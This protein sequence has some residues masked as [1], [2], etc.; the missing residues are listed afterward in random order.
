M[1]IYLQI[2]WQ[3]CLQ[4]II[5]RVIFPPSSKKKNTTNIGGP[6]T[7]NC[8]AFSYFN[9][10]LL[11]EIAEL[12]FT[13]KFLYPIDGLLHIIMSKVLIS[14]FRQCLLLKYL[15]NL[16]TNWRSGTA[17]GFSSFPFLSPFLSFSLMHSDTVRIIS[18][19]IKWV[20]F[21]GYIYT[22]TVCH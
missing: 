18:V 12:F 16:L 11:N 15:T 7:H 5:K 2:W 14:K 6:K 17:G 22:C 10:V 8:V 13:N 1:H 19:P 20:V 3:W 9:S 4:L 21:C